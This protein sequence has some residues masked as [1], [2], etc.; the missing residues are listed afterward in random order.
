[1][2]PKIHILVHAKKVIFKMQMNLI[3]KNVIIV[4]QLVKQAKKIVYPVTLM[5][6]ELE[7][8]VTVFAQII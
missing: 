1:M 3:V 4:V 7:L 5:H 2:I 6:I 8:E